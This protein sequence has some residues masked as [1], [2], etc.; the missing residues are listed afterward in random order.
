MELHATRVATL[1]NDMSAALR[2]VLP[3]ACPVSEYEVAT[4][5]FTD[6]AAAAAVAAEVADNRTM[7]VY[8]GDVD[9][10]LTASAQH[11]LCCL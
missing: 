4:G 8:A 2:C 3:R 5:A 11:E 10:C 7:I 1:T 6:S 9:G